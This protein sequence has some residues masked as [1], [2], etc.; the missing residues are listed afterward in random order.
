MFLKLNI[1]N[2]EHAHRKLDI[3]SYDVRD[4]S[5]EGY[6]TINFQV[7]PV[8][9]ETRGYHKLKDND[10]IFFSKICDDGTTITSDKMY[11]TIEDETRFNVEY[12]IIK[13]VFI[14]DI[15]GDNE[16]VIVYPYKQLN[17]I[18]DENNQI[19]VFELI[20][21]QFIS[22]SGTCEYIN[23][24]AFK[25][26]SKD[27]IDKEK[28]YWVKDETYIY[29]KQIRSNVSIYEYK[30][31]INTI[32]PVSM[33]TSTG[34]DKE[35]VINNLFNEKKK[36][37]IPE[38]IDYEKRCFSP[39]YRLNNKTY[40]VNTLTFNL[41]F[42][43]RDGS[44]DWATADNKGWNQYKMDE[45]G[46]FPSSAQQK[47]GDLIGY[48][49]FT[50]DDIYYRKKKVSKSF[51]RL[52]FYDSINPSSQMLLGYS[53]I[54]LDSAALYEKY[55]A[56]LGPNGNSNSTPLVLNDTVD[57]NRLNVSFIV[58]DRYDD[59]HSSEG[60]YLYL[61]P[62]YINI[63]DTERT[64]YMKAEFNHAGYGRTVPL[65]FPRTI[66][67]V[68]ND[69]T[70]SS[71]PKSFN[72]EWKKCNEA[73]YFPLKVKYDTTLGDYT[74]YFPYS[75]QSNNMVFNLYEPRINSLT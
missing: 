34:I 8:K 27:I 41:Y 58:G 56:N 59:K 19:E 45:N 6:V 38:V 26:S 18:P 42:R 46:N 61:F 29:N 13:P 2:I 60:F 7:L 33:N 54:F 3:E 22:I 25:V 23:P 17:V 10:I 15:I 47:E 53:T 51:L 62:D 65:M 36:E 39:S 1:K 68:I 66:N 73:L 44:T 52:S 35:E 63:D 14:K 30:E 57:D 31:Y 72:G 37:L 43:D 16:N 70:H 48:L 24:F 69:F 64:I 20:D 67:G 12:Q 71:F 28:T 40:Y 49:N 75:K 11:V 32:V 4:G 9:N 21:G 55:I 50:D 74:Y 5:K